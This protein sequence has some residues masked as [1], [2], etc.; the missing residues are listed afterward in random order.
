MLVL[1]KHQTRHLH[2][3]AWIFSLFQLFKIP[4]GYYFETYYSY[5]D[6]S[7]RNYQLTHETTVMYVRLYIL[8]QVL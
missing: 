6:V 2:N 5:Y 8:Y 7:Y 3:D 4:V 1:W